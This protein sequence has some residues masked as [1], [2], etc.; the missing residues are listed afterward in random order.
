MLF[1]IAN[2]EDLENLNE[3][4]LLQNQVKEIRLRDKLGKQDF[5]Q[6]VG[7]LYEPLT[8]ANKKTSQKIPTT[9]SET[10]MTQNKAI[11]NLNN[12]LL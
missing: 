8:D 3:L 10:S 4:V 2:S 6:K 11:E 5:Y 12:K 1:S 7:K 9:I